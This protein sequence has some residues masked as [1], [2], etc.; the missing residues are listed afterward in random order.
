MHSDFQHIGQAFG[1]TSICVYGGAYGE[2]ERAL[3]QG[4]DIVISGTPGRVKDHLD[5]KTLSFEKL[6]FRVLDEADEMLNMG[7]VE[8]IETILNHAKDNA[9]LQT[10]LFSATLPKWVADISKRFLV[11]GYT[12][13]DL[14]GDEKQKASGSVQHMLINCQ[15]SERTDL[16]C[17]LIRAKVPGDGRVIVFCD[18]KRDCG[19]LRRRSRRSSRRARRLSTAT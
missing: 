2:Q 11:P 18:T 10:V 19:E 16:V 8:D 3:R 6:R 12:T 4:C 13:I 17:D 14:V 7:F 15:W 5:R 9:N 1:L